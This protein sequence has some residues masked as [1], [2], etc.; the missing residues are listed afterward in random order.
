MIPVFLKAFSHGSVRRVGLSR[1]LGGWIR[2]LCCFCWL[3]F[4]IRTRFPLFLQYM[5]IMACKPQQM[6][7]FVTVSS[8]VQRW[9]CR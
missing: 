5:S 8:C 2:R 4:V 9:M 1:C 3:G 7:G 6:I